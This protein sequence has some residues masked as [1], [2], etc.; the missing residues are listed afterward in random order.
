MSLI[1]TVYTNATDDPSKVTLPQWFAANTG[2]CQEKRVAQ[3]LSTR[4]IEF[5]LPVYRT[6]SRW[7]NGLRATIERPLFPGYVFVRID[8]TEKVRV[9]ELPGVLSIIG[10]GREPISL[11]TEEI[12]ALREASELMNLEPHAYLNAGSSARV[13]RGPLSGMTGIVVRRKNKTRL[14]LSVDLIMKSVSVEIAEQDLEPVHAHL[15]IAMPRE[16]QSSV[17]EDLTPSI[18]VVE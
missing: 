7:K 9:L 16:T 8:R 14:V 18:P 6:I 15:A 13:L 12:Q 2:S 3:H 17:K 4:D 5:F 1:E 10:A 11:P